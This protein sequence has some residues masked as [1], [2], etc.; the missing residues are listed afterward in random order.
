MIIKDVVVCLSPG[1]CCFHPKKSFFQAHHLC[2]STTNV[3]D[4]TNGCDTCPEGCGFSWVFSSPLEGSLLKKNQ[5]PWN[6]RSLDACRHISWWY[7]VFSCFMFGNLTFCCKH[8]YH[9]CNTHKPW[10]W[11]LVFSVHF[12]LIGPNAMGSPTRNA[13]AAFDLS[14]HSML[15]P[16]GNINT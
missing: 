10:S 6:W 7:S 14:Q 11:A 12:S 9:S 3:S 1:P 4:R 15:A 16:P 5:R 8:Q 13:I 2:K